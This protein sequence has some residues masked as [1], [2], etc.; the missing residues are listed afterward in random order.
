MTEIQ[1][2]TKPTSVEKP[3]GI[4]AKIIVLWIFGLITSF[5]SGWFLKDFLNASQSGGLILV[6]VSFLLFIIIS[7]LQAL[8]V[9]EGDA[10]AFIVILESI[11]MIL[12]FMTKSLLLLLLIPIMF[13]FLYIGNSN[14]RKVVA[15]NLRIDFWS[16]SRVFLPKGIIAVS[17]LVGVLLPFYLTSADSKIFPLS[18][19]L[20]ND[21]ISSGSFLTQKIFPW[22]DPSSTIESMVLTT[23]AEKLNQVPNARFLSEDAKKAFLDDFTA[24]VYGQISSY[25]GSPVN[26]KLTVSAS[27]YKIAEEKFVK[28]PERTK[29]IAYAIGGILLFF[30]IEAVSFPLRAIISILA[31]I[32]FEILLA[33]GFAQISIEQVSREIIIT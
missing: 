3:G 8:F 15:N 28:L 27:I 2:L 29:N 16:A 21:I 9:S 17:I 33:L 1:L 11:V 13:I 31:F 30:A 25:I 6:S 32:I 14:T 24:G 23:A 20:F 10:S 5:A 19:A 22:F 4:N 7:L 26:P 18:P 12:P